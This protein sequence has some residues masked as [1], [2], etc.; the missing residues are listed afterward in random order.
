MSEAIKKLILLSF[1]SLTF[2]VFGIMVMIHNFYYPKLPFVHEHFSEYVGGFTSKMAV[3]L[4]IPVLMLLLSTIALLRFIPNVFPRFLVWGALIL[5]ILFTAINF[6]AVFPMY[7]ELQQ[8][9]FNAVTLDRLRTVSLFLQVLPMGL[10][11]LISIRLMDIYLEE[12]KSFIR[13]LFI[14]FFSLVFYGLG[15]N[16]VESSFY[17]IWH[18]VGPNDWLAYRKSEGSFLVF[19][20][21]YLLPGILLI[22]FT[23]PMLIK[24]RPRGVSFILVLIFLLCWVWV[25][26]LSATYFV[27]KIQIPLDSAYSEQLISDI[28][29]RNIER[30][31]ASI[32]GNIVTAL[33]FLQIDNRRIDTFQK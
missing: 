5:T 33:M 8:T 16:M 23:I 2:Y 26:Y 11:C 19:I 20:I 10:L 17:T 13:W 21:I 4:N 30:Y 1:F 32:L 9:G 29:S 12:T 24:W 7:H 27:P 3:W 15:V 22:F 31:W 28:V 25:A 14:L 6:F 18:W